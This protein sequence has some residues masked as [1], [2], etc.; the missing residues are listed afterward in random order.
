MAK[1]FRNLSQDRA[2]T[3]MMGEAAFNVSRYGVFADGR[4]VDRTKVQAAIDAASNNA[5]SWSGGGKIYFPPGKYLFG[6]ENGSM[7]P[8]DWKSNVDCV[9]SGQASLLQVEATTAGMTDDG[10]IELADV[11]NCRF[12]NLVIHG[13]GDQSTPFDLHCIKLLG[14]TDIKFVDCHF[15]YAP[16]SSSPGTGGDGIFLSQSAAGLIPTRITIE[17]CHLDLNERTGIR[18]ACGSHISIL[19]CIF[20]GT[21]GATLGAGIEVV[22]GDDVDE[23]IEDLLIQGCKISGN[24]EGIY[25]NNSEPQICRN[26]QILGNKIH[27]NDNLGIYMLFSG[28]GAD[29]GDDRT[30][31]GMISDNQITGNGSHGIH[32]SFVSNFPIIGNTIFSNGGKGIILSDSSAMKVMGNNVCMN[33]ED[34]IYIA[35]TQADEHTCISIIG[36]TTLNNSVASSGTYSGIYL[37]GDLTDTDPD[38]RAIVSGNHSGNNAI[39]GAATQR[40]GIRCSDNSD[41]CLITNNS[42]SLSTAANYLNESTDSSFIDNMDDGVLTSLGGATPTATAAAVVLNITPGESGSLVNPVGSTGDVAVL[43]LTAEAVGGSGGGGGIVYLTKTVTHTC[44]SG[45]GTETL[46]AFFPSDC[47][48]MGVV[49]RVIETV[50]GASS[51]LVGVAADTDLFDGNLSIFAGQ[52]TSSDDWTDYPDSM[53]YTT[54]DLTLT[55]GSGTFTSGVVR[56]TLFYRTA[57]APD[58]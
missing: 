17:R 42:V 58:S 10:V 49:A 23:L 1:Q 52:T 35:W 25:I 56:C 7:V 21:S 40:Y 22:P 26:I 41:G 47:L 33:D 27:D 55:A 4:H 48:S 50:V 9:G 43:N 30:E 31:G 28:S 24:T 11:S 39:Y 18:I 6:D 57:T 29:G 32:T 38:V 20:S 15:Q 5:D 45:T 19:N 12:D 34:G 37:V 44:N 8:L 54:S 16:E 14:S 13:A 2:L 46:S 51:I 53:A 36:N 3:S